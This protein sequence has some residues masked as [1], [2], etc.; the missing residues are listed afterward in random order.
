MA[1][2]I[3]RRCSTE[4]R[5]ALRPGLIHRALVDDL[6]IIHLDLVWVGDRP[7]RD[8][9]DVEMLNTMQVGERKGKPLPLLGRDHFIDVDGMNGLI[10][11]FIATT[12]AKG[13][14]ASSEAG[15]EDVSHAIYPL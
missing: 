9:S 2:R 7:T 13:L 4:V 6:A 12:V 8:G 10:T 11:R 14:P 5:R 1:A 3:P 15:Q